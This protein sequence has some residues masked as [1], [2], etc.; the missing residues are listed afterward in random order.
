MS[1]QLSGIK[2][3]AS[4]IK[5]DRGMS[6][7]PLLPRCYPS[8]M[9]SS[10]MLSRGVAVGKR[11]RSV[12]GSTGVEHAQ[13]YR[14]LSIGSKGRT[15]MAQYIHVGIFLITVPNLIVIVLMLVVFAVAVALKLP[16]EH[17][18]PDSPETGEQ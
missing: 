14:V 5:G 8:V 4:Y 1:Q 3:S 10:S 12:I 9:M 18:Q 7:C 11:Y 15:G 13:G 6:S 17:E 2:S 16:Q